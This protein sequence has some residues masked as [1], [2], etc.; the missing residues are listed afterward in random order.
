MLAARA[1]LAGGGARSGNRLVHDATNGARTPPTLSAATKATIDLT[2]GARSLLG[3]EDRAHV[4][5]AQHVAG[6]DDHGGAASQPVSSLCNYR[7]MR[8]RA[9]AKPKRQNYTYSNVLVSKMF[10]QRPSSLPRAGRFHEQ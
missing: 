4:M 3:I 6:T 7:Y 9:Q 8:E 10:R 5:V 2:G 1:A